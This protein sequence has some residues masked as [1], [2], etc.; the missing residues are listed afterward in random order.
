[1]PLNGTDAEKVITA[2]KELAKKKKLERRITRELRELFRSMTVDY[3]AF[4]AQAGGV[5]DTTIYA[6][7]LEGVLLRHY[8]RTSKAFSGDIVKFLKKNI[9]NMDE[10]IIASLQTLS[11]SNAQLLKDIVDDLSGQVSKQV[12]E[13]VRSKASK[14]TLTITRTNQKEIEISTAKAKRQLTLDLGREPTR[15]EVA[16][17]GGA[18]FRNRSFNRVGTIAATTTQV[19]AEST[20]QIERDALMGLT[21]SVD[22]RIAGV[23]P[24]KDKEIWIS[25]GD[26]LVRDGDGNGFNHLAADFQEKEDGVFIVSGEALRFPGDSSQ[27]ASAGN[28]INCRC[29]AVTVIE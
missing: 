10:A 24:L 20:K 1:M 19:A 23:E 27:G 9:R 2:T 12:D 18:I 4:Y 28:I 26:N 22:A 17:K 29:S 21:N 15:R 16:A 7:D 6:A 3:V 13:F 8:R 11:V 14:D 5:F 25:Q